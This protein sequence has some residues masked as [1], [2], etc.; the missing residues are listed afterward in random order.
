MND[1]PSQLGT[2][3]AKASTFSESML[4]W[5]PPKLA[6]VGYCASES[7]QQR[8]KLAILN[9]LDRCVDGHPASLSLSHFGPADVFLTDQH[10][11]RPYSYHFGLAVFV[12]LDLTVSSNGYGADLA[13][14]ACFLEGLAGGRSMRWH[15]ALYLTLGQYP[16]GS[17]ARGD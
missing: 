5:E 13:Y 8:T 1:H 17:L 2:A 9:G 14:D 15:S 12:G 3:I 6:E 7:D 10:W 4:N 16:P 11:K